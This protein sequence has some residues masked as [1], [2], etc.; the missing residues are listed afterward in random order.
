MAKRASSHS[1]A[2]FIAVTILA[3]ICVAPL[4]GAAASDLKAQFGIK[5]IKVGENLIANGASPTADTV[6]EARWGRSSDEFAL[7]EGGQI[8]PRESE[9]KG[10]RAPTNG[11]DTVISEN[12]HFDSVLPQ[13]VPE[14][15]PSPATPAE[16]TRLVV[17]A[18]QRHDVDVGLA[19]AVAMAESRLDR[20]RNSPKGARGPMQLIPETAARFGVTDICDPEENIDAGVRYLRELSGEFRNPLLIAAAYNAGEGRVREYGGLP[21]FKETLGYV[22][23]V[24]N[25]QMDLEGS[26]P[27]SAGSTLSAGERLHPA[28]KTGV[29]TSTERRKWVGGVMHF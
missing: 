17:E 1:I 26:R 25:I 18:A 11:A 16:I 28:G 4:A 15:G 19:V 27:N 6:A 14:C 12:T 10:N 3:S 2:P 9:L 13:S 7:V 20:L 29:I 23:E 21:P 5:R 22:S 8:L 24:L